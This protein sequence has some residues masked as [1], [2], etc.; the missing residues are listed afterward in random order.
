MP[1]QPFRFLHASDLH[2]ERPL[3]GFAETP[4]PLRDLLVDAPYQAARRLFEAAVF[5]EVDFVVLAGD[6][7][8][9]QGV[10]ARAIAFLLEHFE[11]LREHSIA[12]YWAGGRS[13]APQHWPRGA[14]L[15]DNVHV[16]PEGE[17][18]EQTHYRDRLPIANLAGT[19]WQRRH[20]IRASR[21]RAPASGLFSIAVAYGTL[22]AEAL[23]QSEINYWA[24]G[25]QHARRTLLTQPC[26]AHYAGTPQGR[27]PEE[28][29][30]HGCT[31]VHISAE[32]HVRLQP[33]A[34]DSIRWHDETIGLGEAT[35][36]Q[37]VERLL[38]DRIESLRGELGNR[39]ALVTWT[40]TGAKELH[41][42]L[43]RRQLA[44]ELLSSLRRRFGQGQS[45][46]WTLSVEVE[47]RNVIPEAWKCEETLLG[48][49]LRAVEEHRAEGAPPLDLTAYLS[50]QEGM[51][52]VLD[53]VELLGQPQ[54]RVFDE[55]SMLA[56]ALLRGEAR[57]G[58]E[59]TRS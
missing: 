42:N 30:T 23:E 10:G 57:Q 1:G 2:L 5:E 21:F 35:Q 9:P 37:D 11:L 25:G 34:L 41:T 44:T 56:V 15:P 6:V 45:P 54:S 20:G 18:E 16:F 22:N 59:E 48:D 52:M 31:I 33:L 43:S 12:V 53:H 32:G 51:E 46:I 24:L 47:P 19:S 55:A 4:E 38:Q 40:L 26:T 3:H 36:P 13:D 29:G 58:T 8:D 50:D 7:V 14:T 27:S 17:V 49:F 39:P 28:S